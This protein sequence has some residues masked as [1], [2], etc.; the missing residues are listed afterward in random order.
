MREVHPCSVLQTR[1]YCDNSKRRKHAWIEKHVCNLF[2][3][4]EGRN[5]TSGV[6]TRL[7]PNSTQ[8]RSTV[9]RTV[10]VDRS[11]LSWLLQ[12]C[13]YHLPYISIYTLLHLGSYSFT[14]VRMS[15]WATEAAIHLIKRKVC[16][17]VKMIWGYSGG[18]KERFCPPSCNIIKIC[19]VLCFKYSVLHI[20]VAAFIIS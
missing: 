8:T 18:R 19:N 9:T 6:F 5:I 12:T 16:K 11:A 10:F 4:H 20:Y 13:E 14:R 2:F 3:I 7:K 1:V 15:P 17:R